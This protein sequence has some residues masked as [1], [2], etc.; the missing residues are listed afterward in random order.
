MR[1]AEEPRPAVSRIDDPS[2][3]AWG[4]AYRA[5]VAETAPPET[6]SVGPRSLRTATASA[7]C[8][9]SAGKDPSAVW[10]LA[11]MV[12]TGE[13]RMELLLD[14]E[15]VRLPHNARFVRKKLMTWISISVPPLTFEASPAEQRASVEAAVHAAMALRR[16]AWEHAVA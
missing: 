9:P 16:W 6:L 11:H 13:V 8:F 5:I 3:S 1:G 2:R 14:D 15:P 4:D 7:A 10:S 12:D